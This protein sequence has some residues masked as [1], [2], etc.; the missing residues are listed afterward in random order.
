[1]AKTKKYF[2]TIEPAEYITDK[3]LA[4]RSFMQYNLDRLQSMFKYDALPDSMPE[5]MI[6]YA[7]QTNGN[8]FV[9][10]VNGELYALT[11]SSGGEPD[12]YGR[13]TEYVV[14]NPALKISKS[15]KIGVDGVLISN[16]T[17]EIGLLPMLNKYGALIIENEISI[18]TVT[19]YLRIIA[20]L[21][22][23][24]DSTKKSAEKFLEDVLAGKLGVIGESKFFDGIKVQNLGNAS[25]S[26]V[27][28]FI[29]LEQYLKGS[30]FNELGLNANYNMKRESLTQHE[31]TLNEDFLMPL[32]DNMFECR[33]KGWDEVNQ[34][35][36]TEI[37]VDF[38]SAWKKRRVTDIISMQQAQEESSQLDVE[39][40]QEEVD[41]VAEE[42]AI[43]N[44]NDDITESS[45]LEEEQQSEEEEQQSEEEEQLSEEEDE[46]K[47]RG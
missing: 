23:P 14:A 20:L 31:T 19:I 39:E 47:E 25:A 42:T 36:G 32:C 22:A 16:D 29:E 40:M 21:S 18:R 9:T 11:G 24:D 34:M 12:A 26:Y 13:P 38:S 15:Y 7:L 30:M 6:E 44:T 45:Q 41:E 4:I 8:V 10:K 17:S 37:S 28:Q 1:M 33:K 3:D 27:Q 46:E 35:F 2:N 43:D 5:D